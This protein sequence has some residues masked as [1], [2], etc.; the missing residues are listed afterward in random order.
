MRSS[1]P[2]LLLAVSAAAGATAPSAVG[3]DWLVSPPSTPSEVRAWSSP[4]AVPAF[5][6]LELR[7]GLLSRAFSTKP[8]WATVDYRSFL[9]QPDGESLLRAI[10]PEAR[11]TLACSGGGG[12]GD[13]GNSSNSSTYSQTLTYDVGGLLGT[14]APGG[15]DNFLNRTVLASGS[16]VANASAFAYISH[17]TEAPPAPY[18]WSPGARNSPP[19]AAWPPRGVVLV[20][21]FAAPAAEAA[22]VP[23]LA[24]VVV[25]VRYLLYQGLPLLS[26]WVT[27]HAGPNDA[28]MPRAAAAG[29]RAAARCVPVAAQSEVLA[30]NPPWSPTPFLAYAGNVP[31]PSSKPDFRG[32]GK[33]H[34]E[35]T[36]QYGTRVAFTDETIRAPP[37]GPSSSGSPGR[38]SA[39]ARM[40]AA[41]GATP[42]RDGG[43]GGGGGGSL[44][45]GMSDVGAVEPVLTV[46]QALSYAAGR[47]GSIDSTAVLELVLD[48]GPGGGAPMASYPASESLGGCTLGPCRAGDGAPVEGG[49][50]ARAALA[51]RR[52]WRALAPQ[53][54]EA[55]VFMHLTNCTP[56]GIAAAVDQCHEAGF[57]MIVLSFG[58]G[59]DLESADPAYLASIKASVAYA[60][61]RGVEVGGYDLIGWTR[62]PGAINASWSC[63]DPHTGKNT[64]NAFW[65]T[66]WA[67]WL[68][69]RILAFKDATGLSMVELD[70]PYAGYEC[71]SADPEGDPGTVDAQ[72]RNAARFFGALSSAGIFINAPDFWFAQGTHKEGVRARSLATRS[73]SYTPTLVY[74]HSLTHSLT[75]SSSARFSLVAPPLATKPG[76]LQREHL[77][78]AARHA[79]RHRA[80]QPLRRHAPAAEHGRLVLRASGGLPRRWRPRRLRAHVGAPPGVRYGA[81]Q[82]LRRG[83]RHVLARLPAVGRCRLE[84]A[85]AEV[86]GVL[87][88]APRAAE[89]RHRA[90][91]PPGWAGG[92]RVRARAAVVAR[93]R[94]RR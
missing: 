27:V 22:R 5:A 46:G 73:F 29:G 53:I 8:N 39:A 49:F 80:R 67:T 85:G 12:G 74:L 21:S 61:A 42:G 16:A 65:G 31:D 3:A 24:S 15:H 82:R 20:A 87:Q 32:A 47:N 9:D 94:K 69:E 60:N 44:L 10:S 91:G 79:E 51:R 26:K 41:L 45:R 54:T 70:G 68:Q 81:G 35:V 86:D 58:S 59:F 55:P 28:A 7:N 14:G 64:G 19:D 36:Q 72:F 77:L 34:V 50:T 92:G 63:V 33:L 30:L 78:A 4:D 40:M 23:G 52:M 62:D 11:V 25:E 38:G 6:A 2:L 93:R 84:G 1:A 90:H 48:D 83:R 66:G 57:D 37:L 17:H 89:R 43:G 13:A 76:G 88:G 18:A 71:A 75:H 56:A